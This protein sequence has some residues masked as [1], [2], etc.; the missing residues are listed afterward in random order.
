MQR[1]ITSSGSS[2]PPATPAR[3]PTCHTPGQLFH[4]GNRHP[5]GCCTCVSDSTHSQEKP[6][7]QVLTVVC[8]E[9][10]ESVQCIGCW[11]ALTPTICCCGDH[12][13]SHTI[14]STCR[15]IMYFVSRTGVDRH[16]E[17]V[18]ELL[19]PL[20]SCCGRADHLHWCST[21]TSCHDRC[22]CLAGWRRMGAYYLDFIRGAACTS[23]TM[24]CLSHAVYNVLT[25][26]TGTTGQYTVLQCT[27]HVK[28]QYIVQCTC[29]SNLHVKRTSS[30]RGP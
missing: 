13:P 22:T 18:I 8:C 9:T 11:W 27:L 1:S 30:I 5:A 17:R 19:Q 28:E 16:L 14:V 24:Y 23:Y 21:S 12:K 7:S 26:T 15:Q 20:I 25:G 29:L 3:A 6:H 4:A 2:Q 10:V